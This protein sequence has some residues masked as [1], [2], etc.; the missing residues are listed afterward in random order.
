MSPSSITTKNRDVL[1]NLSALLLHNALTNP[2]QIANLLEFQM[3]IR[4]EANQV[5]LR[6][7]AVLQQSDLVQVE[8][9]IDGHLLALHCHVE[10]TAV[11]PVLLQ[12]AAQA[13]DILRVV[14]RLDALGVQEAHRREKRVTDIA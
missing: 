9:V 8:G 14:Q 4:V 3:T 10:H 2:H 5:E 11:H 6:V 7:E 1:I 13:F 12:C